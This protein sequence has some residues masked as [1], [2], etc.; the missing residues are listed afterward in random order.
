TRPPLSEASRQGSGQA[1]GRA[2]SASWSPLL[3]G[4]YPSGL[5]SIAARP[6]QTWHVGLHGLL[7]REGGPAA[8]RLAPNGAGGGIAHSAVHAVAGIGVNDQLPFH[9]KLLDHPA[10]EAFRELVR[11]VHRPELRHDEMGV[12][13]METPGTD[14][15]EMMHADHALPD[16]RAQDLDEAIEQRGVLLVQQ[17]ACCLT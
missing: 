1:S 5:T 13:V 12:H 6:S 14:R 10:G 11:L 9:A 8:E 17:S 2:K 7:E 15:P 3:V 16:A 4:R